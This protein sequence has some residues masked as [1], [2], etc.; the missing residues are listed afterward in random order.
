MW[1]NTGHRCPCA[2]TAIVIPLP[3]DR[4]TQQAMPVSVRHKARQ[5]RS[6]ETDGQCVSSACLCWVEADVE[7]L[8]C[9]NVSI[10]R[11]CTLKDRGLRLSFFGVEAYLEG[12]YT[13]Q[14]GNCRKTNWGSEAKFQGI[15]N[16]Q[17]QVL[18]NNKVFSVRWLWVPHTRPT[19][20]HLPFLGRVY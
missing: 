1:Q 18:E 15:T 20:D 9:L 3:G 17:R 11:S 5:V 13:Y 8:Q 4:E 19:T 16:E 6:I 14:R 10:E 2:I 12:S 7:V